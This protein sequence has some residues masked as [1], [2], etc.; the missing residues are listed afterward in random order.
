MQTCVRIVRKKIS[1][2]LRGKFRGSWGGGNEIQKTIKKGGCPLVD[3]QP[4]D[5]IPAAKAPAWRVQVF[6]STGEGFGQTPP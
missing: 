4:S 2:N 1:E 6:P 3:F 5:P